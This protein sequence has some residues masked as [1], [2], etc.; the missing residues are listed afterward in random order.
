[1]SET[2]SIS[3]GI[4]QRYASAV[5]DLAKDGD[6][7]KDIESDLDAL[8][9]ALND[10]EDFR[11]LISSPVYTRAQQ[12][13]AIEAIAKKMSLSGIMANTLALMATK[14]RL[15]VLPQLIKT[16]RARIADDKGEVVADV[17][18]AKA[19]TKTQSDKLA[20]SLT[21]NTGKTVT[22]QTTVDES[23][24]GGLIVKVG[25]KMIDTSIRS[26]LNSLQNVMKEVG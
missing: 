13:Q 20:K 3:T 23:L 10:S 12:G 26:K 6:K 22:L 24:I 19:L 25:S 2:A 4:A 14:R 8:S 21:A 5:Y 15:F 16:L 9:D 18:S 7:V 1:M 11:D 17:I